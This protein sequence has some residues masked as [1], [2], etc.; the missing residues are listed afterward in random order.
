[1]GYHAGLVSVSLSPTHLYFGVHGDTLLSSFVLNVVH[2]L[3]L[4]QF[5]RILPYKGALDQCLPSFLLLGSREKHF[6]LPAEDI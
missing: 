4:L 1:M 6:N 2:S 5:S 3:L